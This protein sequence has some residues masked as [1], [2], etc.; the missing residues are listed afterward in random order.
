MF[1]TAL[2]RLRVS[3]SIA[4]GWRFS[5]PA[6]EQMVAGMRETYEKFGSIDH[7][8]HQLINGS[9][10]DEETCRQIQLSW[11]RKQA[12]RAASET[13]YYK[14]LFDQTALNPTRLSYAEIAQLPLT[15]KETV[16]Q[17]PDAFVSAKAKPYLRAMTTGTT[18]QP[19]CI[20]FSAHE[21]KV[22]SALSAISYFISGQ[23]TP[24]DIVQLSTSARGTLGNLCLAGGCAQVG[25]QVYLAGI[26]EPALA[27]SMLTETR[28]LAGKK[29]RT[30]IL[31]TYP[32]YL[33]Q[34]VETGL[35]LGYRPVDFGLEKI[36]VGG[37]VVSQGLKTRACQ[38][39][40]EVVFLEGYGMTEIWPVG[41]RLCEAG[42]LHFEPSQG[43]IEIYN[44]QT[45]ALA[46]PGEFGTIVA[47]PFLPYRETTLLLRYDTGDVVRKLE[48]APVCSLKSL[49]A[50][51]K[52]Q[53]KLKLAVSHETSQIY[54]CQLIEA[55]EAVEEIP[56]PARF[57]LWEVAGGLAIEVVATNQT[58]NVRR[59][60][61]TILAQ[62]EIPIQELHLVQNQAQLQYPYPLRCD[63]RE[64]NFN[65]LPK[66]S[67]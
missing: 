52:L 62:W 13:S 33:G 29:P 37:E 38:L 9:V 20:C 2:A 41:G 42:H 1:A 48:Q 65:Q 58:P 4:F 22:Y 32:S 15:T 63:L 49:P 10:L 3:A 59:K 14:Q 16:R 44:P 51:G 8:R 31:Y 35:R 21:L 39:F 28:Q 64:S 47:T 66:H 53:G 11:F 23:I 26:I 50:T 17:H 34:L 56:L 67:L 6:L 12:Q 30:S 7:A 36:I 19:T 43:L 61:E 18:G 25:A 46:L 27:L 40:G 45:Q 60:L 24:E 5:S 54:P 55:L 57:G